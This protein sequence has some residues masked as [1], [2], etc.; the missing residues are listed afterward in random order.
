MRVYVFKS[1]I[2]YAILGMMLENY[3]LNIW[4]SMW[5]ICTRKGRYMHFKSIISLCNPRYDAYNW[6]PTKI[7]FL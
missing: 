5:P 7:L 4:I 1:I 6:H 3:A 2:H